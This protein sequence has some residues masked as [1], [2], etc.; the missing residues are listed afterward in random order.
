MVVTLIIDT[1]GLR[2]FSLMLAVAHVLV[3][4]PIMHAKVSERWILYLVSNSKTYNA[5]AVS[6]YGDDHNDGVCD[7]I[8]LF[9][10]MTT[11]ART[12]LASRMLCM[13][14]RLRDNAVY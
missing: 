2:Y 6:Y 5:D 14:H 1:F 13:C 11:C 10:D 9:V 12:L 3:L 7:L 8:V 4:Y